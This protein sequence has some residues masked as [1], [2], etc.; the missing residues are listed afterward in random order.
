MKSSKNSSE[1]T[2]GYVSFLLKDGSLALL[3][4]Q[5]RVPSKWQVFA[6]QLKLSTLPK[7]KTQLRQSSA[8]AKCSMTECKTKSDPCQDSTT[9]IQRLGRAFLGFRVRCASRMQKTSSLAPGRR[10][11]SFTCPSRPSIDR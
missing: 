6:P 1:K 10:S 2:D 8:N 7:M 9:L 4:I 11:I 5:R 3:P